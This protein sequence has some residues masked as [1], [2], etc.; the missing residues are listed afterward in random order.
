MVDC[1]KHT[2]STS[3][4]ANT[5]FPQ[6]KV[7]SLLNLMYSKCGQEAPQ[8]FG[9]DGQTW[10]PLRQLQVKGNL[11]VGRSSTPL[12]CSKTSPRGMCIFGGNAEVRGDLGLD[13]STTQQLTESEGGTV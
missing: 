3:A 12:H 11:E 8:C 4:A 6:H 9:D 10:E 1:R 13:T 7:C 5:L 2:V